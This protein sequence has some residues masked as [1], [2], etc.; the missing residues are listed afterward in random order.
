MVLICCPLPRVH[1][2]LSG[3]WWI[4]DHITEPAHLK[5]ETQN[6]SFDAH[7][8]LLS[9]NQ[10]S[11]LILSS[12]QH[13]FIDVRIGSPRGRTIATV[14]ITPTAPQKFAD[15]VAPIQDTNQWFLVRLAWRSPTQEAFCVLFGS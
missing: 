13:A 7:L 3:R 8:F 5:S 12:S 6:L 15:F 11:P 9:A 14:P 4:P 2:L 1:G 10:T